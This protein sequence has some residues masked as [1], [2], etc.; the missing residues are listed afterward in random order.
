MKLNDKPVLLEERRQY[1]QFWDFTAQPQTYTV[2]LEPV[3]AHADADGDTAATLLGV[4][5]AASRL[6]GAYGVAS[7]NSAGIDASNTSAWV[8]A[9]G[10]ST[11]FTKTHAANLTANTSFSMGAP[12]VT[13]IAA[14]SA[15]TLAITNGTAAD[16]NSA[17]CHVALVLADYNNYPAPGLKVIASDGGTVSIADGVKGIVALSPGAADNN[18]IYMASAVE[19]F[20]FAERKPIV[21]EALVQFSE[22]NTD[23][24]NVVIGLIDAVAANTL[25]DDGAGVKAN[26]SL[27]CFYKIDGETNWRVRSG[28]GATVKTTTLDADGSLDK[29]THAAGGAAYQVLRMEIRPESS[30]TAVVDYFIGTRTLDGDWGMS[31]VAKHYATIT[32]ATEMQLVAGVKNGG[33]NAETL[34][35]DRI[36]C[37]ELR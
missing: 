32:S 37:V 29:L 17:V 3:T 25:V 18:E 13:D 12:T 31:H 34:N 21:F 20:K 5:P 36:G 7:V 11:A 2:P 8:L 23:D 19:V 33:A 14:G 15:V 9:I 24:A 30:T 10:G 27:A 28:V 22:A 4:V 26:S 6:V 35:V 1:E 16:L